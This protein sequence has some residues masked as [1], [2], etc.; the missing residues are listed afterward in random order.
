MEKND[1][2]LH[3][4]FQ[5]VKVLSDTVGLKEAYTPIHQNNVSR[6][7]RVIGQIMGLREDVI[8]GL[9][10]GGSLHDYGIIRIPSE[11]LS[12]PGKL[13]EQEYDIMKQH[14]VHG[15]QILKNI[16]YPWPVARMILQ[17]HE[18]LD[19]SGYPAGLK[20]DDI[21]LEARILAVADI[22][23]SMTSDRPWRRAFS[24]DKALD[25]VKKFRETKYDAAVVD[26]AVELYT[27]Q[28]DR[29]KP[30]FYGRDDD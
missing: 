14:P 2:I 8:S 21:I 19:G 30:D 17:H 24:I 25:E 20:G 29:L 22:V 12:K 9:R 23:D 26:A 13:T 3:S 28:Q 15:F 16:D 4:L 27:N 1:Q 11:I 18:R 6:V 10:I 7:S 5:T